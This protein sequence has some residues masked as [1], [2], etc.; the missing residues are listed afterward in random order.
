MPQIKPLLG[1]EACLRGSDRFFSL[2]V[3]PD[4]RSSAQ[5][6]RFVMRETIAAL[7]DA[8]ALRIQRNSLSHCYD[9]MCSLVV[10]RTLDVPF[11]NKICQNPSENS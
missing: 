2:P 3:R 6:Y 1:D 11:V 4:V 8:N 10:C 5:F 9:Y 7:V